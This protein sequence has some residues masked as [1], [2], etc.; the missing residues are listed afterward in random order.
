MNDPHDTTA[1]ASG[2]TWVYNY[3]RVG[4]ILSKSCHRY[5][6]GTPGVAIMAALIKPVILPALREV[7]MLRSDTVGL[8]VLFLRRSPCSPSC[9]QG[10]HQKAPCCQALTFSLVNADQHHSPFRRK[11]RE[12]FGDIP[13]K[14][15]GLEYFERSSSAGSVALSAVVPYPFSADFLDKAVQENPE[16][17]FVV[18]LLA[19]AS[20]VLCSR[21]PFEELV[22]QG[23]ADVSISISLDENDV[24]ISVN[25]SLI[26][27][28]ELFRRLKAL[29]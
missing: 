20:G 1:G 3:D 9:V 22:K 17:I 26:P 19:P 8:F 28:R 23:I 7:P 18:N 15:Q 29:F 21:R 4:N 16:N 25:K 24:L 11:H 13:V 5:T 2:T 27:P 12:D 10:Y 6:T 14:D